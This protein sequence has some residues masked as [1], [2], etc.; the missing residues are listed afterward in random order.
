LTVETLWDSEELRGLAANPAVPSHLLDDFV[1]RA[2][3]RLAYLLADRDDLSAEQVRALVDRI[4][5]AG[6]FAGSVAG[7]LLTR[8][9]VDPADLPTTDP[10][11]ALRVAKQPGAD[12]ALIR[13]LAG[14]PDPAV[15]VVLA[16]DVDQLPADVVDQLAHDLVEEVRDG[17]VKNPS[18][19]LA[20]LVDLVAHPH[21]TV[22]WDLAARSDLPHWAYERLST[23]PVPGVRYAVATNPVVSESILRAMAEVADRYARHELA[24]N[25]V[26]P[27]DLLASMAASTR[28][29]PTLLPRIAAA[30]EAEL[31]V[32]AGSTTMQVR[33]LVA[34]RPD[35]P[36]DLIE[37]LVADPDAGVVRSL[38]ANPLLT[39]DQLWAVATRYG[40]RLYPRTASNPNCPVDLLRHM[41][42]NGE[43]VR[44]VYREIAKHLNADAGLLALCLQDERARPHA[45][46]N[47]KPARRDDPRAAR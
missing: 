1:A 2:N 30:S 35:L 22:R 25:P 46:R 32:L 11:V 13:W 14:H 6:E 24:Q 4:P 41:A 9:L 15:R 16:K 39:A 5:E 12:P 3:G 7:V 34:E 19:P 21:M 44:K 18:T 23:D 17:L 36:A 27:L 43:T 40:P 33:M 28:I 37:L 29:G 8:G 47:P 20:M 38:A 26:I 31:R 10:Q 45:A 42:A